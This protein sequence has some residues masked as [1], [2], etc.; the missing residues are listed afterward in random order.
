[1][2]NASIAAY[3]AIVLAAVSS[4][5]GGGGSDSSSTSP[6]SP[7]QPTATASL[8]GVAASG[9]ALKGATVTAQC[10]T[11][12]PVT[13]IAAADGSFTLMLDGQQVTPCL[14]SA[15]DPSAPLL[16]YGYASQAGRANITPFTS[17]IVANA[18]G[19]DPAAVF[20]GFSKTDADRIQGRL[21]SSSAYLTAQ[22][23]SL[24]LVPPSIDA[25]SGVFVVGDTNDVLL[26]NFSQQTRQAGRGY[27]D[28]LAA[29]VQG[30]NLL[31]VLSPVASVSEPS[32]PSTPAGLRATAV[33]SNSVSL[34]WTASA[35]GAGG[36]YSYAIYRDG[37]Q[38]ASTKPDVTQFV[39]IDRPSGTTFSYSVTA[40]SVA[41]TTSQRSELS[42]AATSSFALLAPKLSPYI[43]FE[44]ATGKIRSQMFASP[45][46]MARARAAERL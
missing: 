32:A 41:G 25:L 30:A 26:D 43:V 9:A 31:A 10:T 27:S 15:A 35:G 21:A 2:N 19:Q 45:G 13:T 20:A 23:Q 36:I 18:L 34:A 22:L 14:L 5:C 12:A 42:T 24:R 17:L 4:G 7:S 16:L 44:T 39:D 1:M 33:S 37:M 46:I 40:T 11:G 29:A 8:F 28:M 3:F 38:I 6:S